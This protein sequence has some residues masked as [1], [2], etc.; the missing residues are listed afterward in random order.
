MND[1]PIS[2]VGIIGSLR[3]ESANRALFATATE[4]V[5]AGVT[6]VEAPIVDVPL[7]NGDV[8]AAGDP[9]A[10]AALKAAVSGADGVIFFTPE[11]NRSIPAV[12]KNALDWASRVPGDSAIG[13]KPVGIV[14][15]SPGRHDVAGVRAALSETVA[16]A[17]ARPFDESLGLGGI[18]GLIEDGRVT[19][20]ATRASLA[21]FLA[22]FADFVRTPVEES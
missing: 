12:T 18:F 11:Y 10:V 5:P 19:D 1:T 9:P 3:A 15:A 21:E 13:G 14:G 17:M 8:E 2:L 20:E 16:G 4:L 22:R 7:Y 6:L